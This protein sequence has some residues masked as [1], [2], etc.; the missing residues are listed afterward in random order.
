MAFV[1]LDVSNP[2]LEPSSSQRTFDGEDAF[3]PSTLL[4]LWSELLAKERM[5]TKLWEQMGEIEILKDRCRTRPIMNVSML[6]IFGVGRLSPEKE[7]IRRR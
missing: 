7:T 1:G 6:V 2:E 3:V 5:P 4:L